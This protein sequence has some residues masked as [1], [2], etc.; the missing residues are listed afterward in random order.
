MKVSSEVKALLTPCDYRKNGN[1]F[2][3]IE[4]GFYKLLQFQ[5][6]AYGDY[7]F[8]NAGLHPVGLPLLYAGQLCI[9]ERP[10]I[11]QCALRERLE[12]ITDKAEPFRGA[13]VGLP[14]G[15][16]AQ[17]LT[18]VLPDVERWLSTWGSCAAILAAPLE[19]LS[20]LFSA[21]PLVWEREFYLLK[22][23]CAWMSGDRAQADEYFCICRQKNP[24]MD[25][26]LVDR[27]M[28]D[29]TSR[30]P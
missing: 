25:F 4:D 24:D 2:W 23:Y 20:P 8:L 3:K 28:S 21:V 22:A 1:S 6:G 30:I 26:S 7:F 17:V 19:A 15:T 14:Q 16:E 5:G 18:A 27:H 29:L 13:S 9:P 10:R 11:T 12:Q